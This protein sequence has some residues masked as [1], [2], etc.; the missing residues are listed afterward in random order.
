MCRAAF[1]WIAKGVYSKEHKSRSERLSK[2]SL[3]EIFLEQFVA[4][5]SR[6]QTK[7]VNVYETR[8]SKIAVTAERKTR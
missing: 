7:E 8:R 2:A 3:D 4:Q 6:G 1:V 5:T